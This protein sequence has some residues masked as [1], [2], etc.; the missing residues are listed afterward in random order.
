GSPSESSRKS[1]VNVRPLA[2]RNSVSSRVSCRVRSTER[3]S[4]AKR[5]PSNGLNDQP[6]KDHFCLPC[7]DNAPLSACNAL[8]RLAGCC[9]KNT[10]FGTNPTQVWDIAAQQIA[11]VLN[12]G[13]GDD[14]RALDGGWLGRLRAVGLMRCSTCESGAGRNLARRSREQRL[15]HG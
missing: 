10:R 13:P 8:A 11:G 15:Q 12:G 1:R 5:L 3:P 4:G 6:A 9:C 2:C 14:P 7:P